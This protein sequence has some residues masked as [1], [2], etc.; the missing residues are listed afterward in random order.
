M[1]L[2]SFPG[3]RGYFCAACLVLF[4]SPPSVTAAEPD[5]SEYRIP[6]TLP[7]AEEVLRKA[8]GHPL[9]GPLKYAYQTYDRLTTEIRDYTCV[10]IKRERIRGEMKGYY[11]IETKVRHGRHH[12]G[13][14]KATPFSVY[15]QFLSPSRVK[16][17][18]ILFV[19]GENDGKML[20]R[21]GGRVLP[22]LVH[23]L[24]PDGPFAMRESN[25]AIYEFGMRSM[26]SG[27]INVMIQDLAHDECEV[28]LANGVEINGRKCTHFRVT[29][30]VRQP[31]FRFHLAEVYV[32]QELQVPVYY[33]AYSWPREAGGPPQLLEKFVYQDVRLNVG[34]GGE[35]FD[36]DNPNYG[37]GKLKRI[38]ETGQ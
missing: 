29:H 2:P 37:F 13:E 28:T 24:V 8:E 10:F 32:D 21:Q 22:N 18:E 26:V 5:V 7:P 23:R 11:K 30:P 14:E 12:E 38:L 20:V 17:R 9:A 4:M 15:M 35:D 25:Y 36:R 16:G 1:L 6:A 19:E 31:H 34:L 27:L 3:W 33:A